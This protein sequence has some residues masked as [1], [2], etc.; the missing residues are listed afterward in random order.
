[1]HPFSR[2]HKVEALILTYLGVHIS[3]KHRE[4]H[5]SSFY[6]SIGL[7]ST[8]LKYLSNCYLWIYKVVNIQP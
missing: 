3:G 5:L 8:S 7:I 6:S 4:T 1:M 2:I